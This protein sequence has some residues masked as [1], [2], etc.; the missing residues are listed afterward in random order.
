MLSHD[1][2]ALCLRLFSGVYWMQQEQRGGA[3]APILNTGERGRRATFGRLLG[4]R[5]A[6]D[7]LWKGGQCE[8]AGSHLWHKYKD[9]PPPNSHPRTSR[10][11]RN[12]RHSKRLFVFLKVKQPVST[13]VNSVRFLQWVQESVISSDAPPPRSLA[14]A[15]CSGSQGGKNLW[16]L[17]TVSSIGV[18]FV[19]SQGS[20]ST[21]VPRTPTS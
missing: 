19:L 5:S 13:T 17:G 12:F 8:L 18:A 6:N 10:C 21:S 9:T 16:Q 3:Y 7:E 20:A 11:F 4:G 15:H 14:L 1:R 2:N